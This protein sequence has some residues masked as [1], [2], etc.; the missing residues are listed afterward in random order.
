MAQIGGGG[1]AHS[2]I[3]TWE[4]FVRGGG[5]AKCSQSQIK[6]KKK[7]FGYYPFPLQDHPLPSVKLLKKIFPIL[8]LI[9]SPFD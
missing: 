1:L 2:Q 4:H 9:S 8:N 6:R 7:V 3:Q 5:L